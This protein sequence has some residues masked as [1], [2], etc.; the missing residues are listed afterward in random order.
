M[1]EYQYLFLG[2]TTKMTLL[3]AITSA[4]DIAL[5]KD[6]TACIFGE[7]VAFGGVFRRDLLLFCYAKHRDMGYC[8]NSGK[9]ESGW[10]VIKTLFVVKIS[11]WVQD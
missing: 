7:D 5:D 8:F 4:M 10:E 1:M 3:Q 2:E 6:P 9:F 11:R